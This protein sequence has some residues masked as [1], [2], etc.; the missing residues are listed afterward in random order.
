MTKKVQDTSNDNCND[1]GNILNEL[2]TI[3]KKPIGPNENNEYEK[4][5]SNCEVKCVKRKIPN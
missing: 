5:P 1:V 2:I 4:T 3:I